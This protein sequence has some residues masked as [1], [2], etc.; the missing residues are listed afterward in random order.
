MKKE[1]N[2][3]T[4]WHLRGIACNTSAEELSCQLTYRVSNEGGDFFLFMALRVREKQA[5]GCSK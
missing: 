2:V 1:N 5:Q 4:L 3:K